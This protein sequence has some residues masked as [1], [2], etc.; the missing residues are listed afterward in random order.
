MPMVNTGNAKSTDDKIKELKEDIEILDLW[1]TVAS[2]NGV[3]NM[4][5]KCKSPPDNTKCN[6]NQQ[7]SN[8]NTLSSNQNQQSKCNDP[9]IP[10]NFEEAQKC[11]KEVWNRLYKTNK[12]DKE[13]DIGYCETTLSNILEFYSRQIEDLSKWKRF[14]MIYGGHI[15]L[16]LLGL[17]VAVVFATLVYNIQDHLFNVVRLGNYGEILYNS[18]VLGFIAGILRSM[19]NVVHEARVRVFRRASWPEYVAAPFIA[20][21]LAFVI[22]LAIIAGLLTGIQQQSQQPQQ[23]QQQNPYG[24]YVIALASGLFWNKS[25]N[26]LRKLLGEESKMEEKEGKLSLLNRLR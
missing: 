9:K 13:Q 10:S 24:V 6:N 25:I 14:Y 17:L 12:E 15:L 23:Q 26:I 20:G 18:T 3:F 8:P 19:Y 22:A 1:L 16:Y 21:I 4:N 7:S 2:E 5:K 11:L